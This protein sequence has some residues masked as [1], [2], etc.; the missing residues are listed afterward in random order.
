MKLY[1][2]SQAVELK[3]NQHN[4]NFYLLLLSANNNGNHVVRNTLIVLGGKLQ[5]H[6]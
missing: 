6:P 4:S 5:I 1:T 2:R 3:F